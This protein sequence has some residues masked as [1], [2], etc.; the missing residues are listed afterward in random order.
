MAIRINLRNLVR[1]RQGSSYAQTLSWFDLRPQRFFKHAKDAHL[2]GLVND[3]ELESLLEIEKS[4]LQDYYK[5]V[6]GGERSI[7][8]RG[9]HLSRENNAVL[10]EILLE[11]I[12]GYER[13]S[14]EER[15]Q[16]LREHVINYESQTGPKNGA[17][18]FFID[19]GLGG[20]L[21][22]S[23][24]LRKAGSPL[25]T[26]ELINTARSLGLFDRT[27]DIYL[28]RWEITEKSMWQGRTGKELTVEATEDILWRIPGY[29]TANREQRITL[30]RKHV[31]NYKSLTGRYN[32]ALQFFHDNGLIG[33]LCTSPH[34]RKKDSPLATLELYNT[35]RSLGLFDRTQDV[36]LG[37][38]EIAERNMWQGDDGKE[39]AVEAVEDVLWKIPRY[40]NETR[41]E[42]I[43]LI[44]EHMINY[45][46]QNGP[47]NGATQFFYDNGLRGMITQSPHLRKK[48]SPTAAIELYDKERRIGLF[49]RSQDVYLGRWEIAERNMWQGRTGKELAVE[50]AEDVLWKIPGYRHGSREE[51]IQLIRTH[52]LNY[53]SST[54]PKTERNNSFTT[55]DYEACS[56]SPSTFEKEALH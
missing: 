24:H 48:C 29:R 20:M 51:R 49:D 21:T 14:R 53:K 30:I 17:L 18:Q 12:E 52:I 25:A 35:T 50:A 6:R 32:G 44:R 45:T 15:V 38:W 55:T 26:L 27:E 23:P 22:T 1:F 8:P 46:T 16:L 9:T 37:K 10:V 7:L 43:Q 2:E 31:I 54:G 4:T 41:E 19:N 28:G 39:L 42:R 33:M 11:T 3:D 34:L 56:F 13:A 40:C 47:K 36:Y 5:E